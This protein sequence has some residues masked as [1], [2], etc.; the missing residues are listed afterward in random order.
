MVQRS[1]S[2]MSAFDR[3]SEPPIAIPSK[4]SSPIVRGASLPQV[5]VGATLNDAVETVPLG[6]TAPGRQ[7]A[8]GPAVGP[9]H[10]LSG[11]GQVRQGR[12]AFVERQH[13]IGAELPLDLDRPLGSQEVARS[14]E[15]RGEGDSLFVDPRQPFLQRPAGA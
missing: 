3:P 12:G 13:Q 14:V 10:R 7:A 9:L 15:V 5:A 8:L 4:G 11:V 6:A 2:C 1:T